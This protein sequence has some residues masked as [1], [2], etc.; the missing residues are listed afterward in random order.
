[1]SE[2]F[3]LVPEWK[4][5]FGTRVKNWNSYLREKLKLVTEWKTEIGIWE[6]TPRLG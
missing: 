1:M 5:E 2:K 4:S 6:K 3:K